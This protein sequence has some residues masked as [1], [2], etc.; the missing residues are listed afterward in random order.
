MKSLKNI[1]MLAVLLVA[2]TSCIAQIKNPTTE[3]FTIYGNCGMCEKTIETAGNSKKTAQVDWNKDTK[4]ASITYDAKKTNPDEILKRIALAGYDSDKFL[5]PDAAY[6]SLHGCCQYD[7]VAK[8]VIESHESHQNHSEMATTEIQKTNELQSV[9]ATYFSLKDAL[10]ATDA[11][12][13][14]EFATKLISEIDAVKM[15]QLSEKEHVVWMKVMKN[16]KADAVTISTSKAIEKQRS[17]FIL[18]SENMH[19]LVKASKL[20]NIIYYEFCPMANDGKGAHWLSQEKAIKNPYYGSMML[21]CGKV[22]ETI[23]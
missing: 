1:M 12:A 2:T 3:E 23:E 22:V 17:A 14:S 4:I 7:R 6:N 21:S 5:A 15:N 19:A 20:E 8:T 18:F 11:V 13:T 9:F 16:L 10:V